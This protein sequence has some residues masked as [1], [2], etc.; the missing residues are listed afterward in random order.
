VAMRELKSAA[1]PGAA[2]PTPANHSVLA[3]SILAADRKGVLA[4]KAIF[5]ATRA[6]QPSR[7]IATKQRRG[8]V[9]RKKRS[10]LTMRMQKP[11]T[12]VPAT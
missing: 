10:R 3:S 1:V 4:P 11:A 9:R 5:P 2:H 12:T 8:Q 6:A 7:S